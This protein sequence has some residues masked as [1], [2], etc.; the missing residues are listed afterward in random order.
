MRIFVA[1]GSGVLG[2]PLVR[3]LVDQG[4][5]VTATTRSADTAARVH[6][7]G[8]E[9][10]VLDA[11]DA[12]AVRTAVTR[13]RPEGLVNQL[14]S[15]STPAS[16]YGAWLET[17]NRLRAEAG[18][19]LVLAAREAGTRR[20]VAQSA[21][22]MT[23]PDAPAPTDEWSPLYTSAPGPLLGHVLANTALEDVVTGTPG[24][25][26]VVLRYGFLYGP[27]TALGPG[28]DLAE[29]VRTGAL[30]VVGDGS[31]HYPFVSTDD[32]VAATV[33]AVDRGSPGVYNVVDDD[34]A[35]QAVWVPYLA[36]LLGGP[37][38]EHV[39]EAEALERVGVQA[40][41]YG[42]RLRAASNARAKAELG[43][44]PR[45]PSWREGFR[46]VFR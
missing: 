46:T 16:D 11:L 22:F 26:G 32:A 9:A 8:A 24:I 23:A 18:R 20:V 41:Y 25:E 39:S 12:D 2:R 33:L 14:T 6:R 37:A 42:A 17:T 38:P 15:L 36:D 27:G 35:A 30:P 34:P 19:T 29:A 28:G 43:W 10:V 13:A 7:L 31:G 21:S 3:A 45:H 5:Q 44:V 1:G 40:V 4:H